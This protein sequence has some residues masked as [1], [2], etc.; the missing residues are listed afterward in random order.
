MNTINTPS[1][2]GSPLRHR[3]RRSVSPARAPGRP[4]RPWLKPRIAV[5]HPVH[6]QLLAVHVTQEQAVAWTGRSRATVA[7]WAAAGACPDLAVARLLALYA[8]GC[9]PIPPEA[10]AAREAQQWAQFSFAPDRTRPGAPWCLFT[11]YSREGLVW[12]QV[13]DLRGSLRRFDL[14]AAEL[15]RWKARALAAE[16]EA[17]HWRDRVAYQ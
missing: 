4:A 1:A 13:D 5:P 6:P 14:L 8:H 15:A 17:I 3:P 12:A 7:R 16:A 9:P 2:D 10:L 11:P